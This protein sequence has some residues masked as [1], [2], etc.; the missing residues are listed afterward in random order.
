MTVCFPFVVVPEVIDA[1]TL[2]KERPLLY[3]AIMAAAERNADIQKDQVTS[4]MQYLALH[5]L[6]LGEKNCKHPLIPYG[7]TVFAVLTS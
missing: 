4:I 7:L 6:Q 1:R 3:R 2:L 5:V